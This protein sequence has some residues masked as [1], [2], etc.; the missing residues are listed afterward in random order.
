MNKKDV[1]AFFDKQASVWDE[2]SIKNDAVIEKILDNTV[3][4]KCMDILDVACGT[5]VMFEY[6]LK[7]G[8]ASVTGIDISPKMVEI[9]TEKFKNEP[10]IQVIC[11]DVEEFEFNQ[12]FDRIIVYNAFPHFPDPER[13]IKTL[14]GLLKENG[15][16]TVAHGAGKKIIDECHKAAKAVSNKLMS[17]ENL[18][19]IFDKFLDVEVV[20]SNLNMYQVSGIKR[21]TNHCV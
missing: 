8:A 19:I 7:R 6:Y 15:R 4:E 13:L 1:I 9:A 12:K 2:T 11:G 21:H 3:V 10:K 20:I 17:A 14:S 16:L 5:G 18:K